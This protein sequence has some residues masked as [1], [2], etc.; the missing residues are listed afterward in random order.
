MEQAQIEKLI[1]KVRH[2]S[3]DGKCTNLST[4]GNG[5][6]NDTY[7]ATLDNNGE[8][9]KY[10]LQ[11]INHLVFKNPPQLM[12]NLSRVSRHLQTKPGRHCLRV[13]AAKDGQFYHQDADGN[14]WRLMEYIEGVKCLEVP[15]NRKQAYEAAHTFGQFQADL[16]DMPGDPLIETIPEFHNTQKRY[17][18][19]EE[20]FNQDVCGRVASVAEWI[21]FAKERSNL[22]SILNTE[23]LPVR[24][25]HNDTKLNNVLLDAESE[26]GVCAID[27][28]TVMP[29][30]VLHD[31]GDLVR[32]AACPV[33]EDETDLQKVEF[34][35]VTFEAI[36]EGYYQATCEF[37][38]DDEI[39]GLSKAPMVITYELGLRFLTDYLAGDTYF[40]INY[41]EHNLNRAKV[42]F[43]LVSSMEENE[44]VMEEMVTR[45]CRNQGRMVASG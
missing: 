35:P 22:C 5:N 31:F 28:D 37:L 34:L 40:K 7:V 10:T 9:K 29:G 39:A 11:R 3:V 32:T 36:V 14:Y 41:P 42:Q 23:K 1:E 27:L 19:F 33:S 15:Q 21:D 16:L 44:S 30:C 2:F 43:Q 18:A 26:K 6:V 25:V 12:D 45:I 38:E 8:S 4:N 13:M 24:V 20:V 17:E